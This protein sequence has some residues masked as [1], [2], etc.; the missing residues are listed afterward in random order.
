MIDIAPL[1]DMLAES[2]ISD[3]TG[4]YCVD[5]KT[6]EFRCF[7][8]DPG[9]SSLHI[10]FEGPDFYTSLARDTAKVVLREDLGCFSD[11]MIRRN[12]ADHIGT[13]KLP[14]IRFRIII[15]SRPI[16]HTLRMIRDISENNSCFIIGLLNIDAEVRIK[17]ESDKLRSEREIYSQIAES[18]AGNYDTLYYVDT[19]S[20]KYFEFSAA[21]SYRSLHVPVIGQDFFAETRENVVR[22]VCPEDRDFAEGWYYRENMMKALREK[23]SFSYK[24]RLLIKGEKI[25]YRFTVILAEDDKHIIVCVKNIA[26]EIAAAQERLDTHMRTITYNQI[27]ETLASKYDVIYYVDMVN[28]SYVQFM[29]NPIYG[30]LE[31]KEEGDDFFADTIENIKKIVHP[32]DADRLLTLIGKDHLITQLDEKKQFRI[33]YRLVING[34]QQYT[35]LTAMWSSDKIHVIIGVENIDEEVRRETEQIHALNEANEMARRDSLTGTKNKNAYD[36]LE[37]SVQSNLDNGID[38]LP[39]AIVVCDLNDLKTVNDSEGHRAGDDYIRSASQL[40]CGIFT[41]SPVF[42]I[43]GDEFAVFIRGSD[44][45]HRDELFL[46]LHNTVAKNIKRGSGPVIAAGM[47]VYDK[48]TDRR[49]SDV[50]ERA[51]G[52]MYGDKRKLKESGAL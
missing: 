22:Y 5:S 17:Q 44:Y 51:D 25:Y 1:Y 49:M 9:F 13:G 30:S 36:E 41:H 43:G 27:A 18:L 26:D 48:N 4:V 24:Y 50:F 20:G 38:Y 15:N 7:T 16:Y 11:E 6:G 37:R 46:T 23:R 40:I 47:A 10:D 32:H 35:R 31:I 34:T 3:Y 29:A 52:M 19:E 28:G 14:Y 12:I 21:D 33:E 39:F 2:T 42:R 45:P 8:S